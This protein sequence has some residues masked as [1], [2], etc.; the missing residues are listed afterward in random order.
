MIGK[1]YLI[2]KHTSPSGKCYIGQTCDYEK[3]C[4]NHKKQNSNC[5]AFRNARMKYGLEAVFNKFINRLI[6]EK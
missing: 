2:Y 4:K 6:T 3:R 1:T 5:V